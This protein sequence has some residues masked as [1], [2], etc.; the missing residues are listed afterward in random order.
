MKILRFGLVLVVLISVIAGC[1][2]MRLNDPGMV[3]Y[4]PFTQTSALHLPAL[5]SKL[6]TDKAFL[7]RWNA[8]DPKTIQDPAWRALHVL[9]FRPDPE[10]PSEGYESGTNF[11][12]LETID[13]PTHQVPFNL[14][15]EDGTPSE[16]LNRAI[17]TLIHEIDRAGTTHVVLFSHGW[18]QDEVRAHWRYTEFLN[19][20]WRT[21]M[22]SPL[23]EQFILP[24][25]APQ[26][27]PLLVSVHWP[28]ESSFLEGRNKAMAVGQSDLSQILWEL[29]KYRH[30]SKKP[31]KIVL[32]GHS[33]GNR[34]MLAAA[35]GRTDPLSQTVS[36]HHT[37]WN[38]DWA[39]IDLYIGFQPAMDS[40]IVSP[41]RCVEHDTKRGFCD[42]PWRINR[43][44]LTF[45]AFD[46]ANRHAMKS[47]YLGYYGADFYPSD[48]EI[49]TLN[50]NPA[51][52]VYG[53]RLLLGQPV[54]EQIKRLPVA[55]L[56]DGAEPQPT[57]IGLLLVDRNGQVLQYRWPFD[58]FLKDQ[59]RIIKL[60]LSRFAHH[61]GTYW[62]YTD[63][64][65]EVP[66]V[67]VDLANPDESSMKKLWQRLGSG[68]HTDIY[69]PE[70]WLFM[71]QMVATLN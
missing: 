11:M 14:I 55:T 45:S 20:M 26:F 47:D 59:P 52:K 44:V 41:K 54:W 50:T 31:F 49:A 40:D 4:S 13:W 16:R 6:L 60:D 7:D 17:H 5:Q 65:K 37:Q 25:G 67:R 46:Y 15:A 28:S 29:I 43:F 10:I 39:P 62:T 36:H 21:L 61:E 8:L 70:I 2:M 18:Q 9:T 53:S 51:W 23:R 56:S 33:F 19:G 71:W 1:E 35:E 68:A 3:L 32:A 57:P 63:L 66:K 58:Q 34:V 12:R 48:E 38:P 27:T 22:L 24:T 64:K 42:V 30:E 69:Y